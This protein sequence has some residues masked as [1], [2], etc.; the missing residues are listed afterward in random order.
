VKRVYTIHIYT[1]YND[2]ENSSVIFHYSPFSY[3]YTSYYINATYI[4]LVH[5]HLILINN[6]HI[7]NVFVAIVLQSTP[8]YSVGNNE[9]YITII[10]NI[11]ITYIIHVR[12]I[13]QCLKSKKLHENIYS[14]IYI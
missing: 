10:N 12:Y 8:Q 9:T 5:L 3:D 2:H 1:L 11:I 13:I 14:P 6:I 4:L 7:N